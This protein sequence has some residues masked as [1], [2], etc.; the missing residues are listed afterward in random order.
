MNQQKTLTGALQLGENL[1]SFEL[2]ADHLQVWF[3]AANEAGALEEWRRGEKTD[4]HTKK[5][6]LWQQEPASEM[7]N[8]HNTQHGTRCAV[9][10]VFVC[11]QMLRDGWQRVAVRFITWNPPRVKNKYWPCCG[12]SPGGCSAGSERQRRRDSNQLMSIQIT[13]ISL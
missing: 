8:I 6:L 7:N 9:S 1:S 10:C 5:L 13:Q 2:V 11:R 12:A 3:D 4:E